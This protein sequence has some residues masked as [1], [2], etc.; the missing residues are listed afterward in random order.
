MESADFPHVNDE[1]RVEDIDVVDDA[2]NAN[3]AQIRPGE[4][5]GTN[6]AWQPVD[7]RA[8]E[9]LDEWQR[10][11]LRPHDIHDNHDTGYQPTDDS[12]YEHEEANDATRLLHEYEKHPDQ[13]RQGHDRRSNQP[14]G[15][16]KQRYGRQRDLESDAT[17][18]SSDYLALR[19]AWHTL[20]RVLLLNS[21][22]AL[23]WSLLD[24]PIV[25]L[26]R[27]AVCKRQMS[28]GSSEIG[29]A[30][31]DT[32]QASGIFDSAECRTE[33]VQSGVASVRGTLQAA[34]ALLGIVMNSFYGNMSDAVGRR[35][36]LMMSIVLLFG[37]NVWFLYM[38]QNQQLSP[39]LALVGAAMLGAAG[40]VSS[41]P[42]M[43]NSII[44][45]VAPQNHQSYFLGC[46][47]AAYYIGLCIG[48]FASGV[49]I[50]TF[51]SLLPNLVATC[52]IW[53]ICLLYVFMLIPETA[54]KAAN[55]G[56]NNRST[57]SQGRELAAAD[58]FACFKN[59]RESVQDL[60][61]N[62]F[63]PFRGR[64]PFRNCSP[65][66]LE[67]Q[68]CYDDSFSSKRVRAV[69]LLALTMALAILASGAIGLLPLFV[70][71][72]FGWG[73]R[74]A[75]YLVT[76]NPVLSAII[77][78]LLL[79]KL[80]QL[81]AKISVKRER[82]SNHQHTT[83]KK[84][85]GRRNGDII[86]NI[87][88]DNSNDRNFDEISKVRANAGT[89]S[90]DEARGDASA[91]PDDLISA[92]K[93]HNND[94]DRSRNEDSAPNE[95]QQL[96]PKSVYEDITAAQTDLQSQKPRNDRIDRS[97][98]DD[99]EDAGDEDDDLQNS[100][101][102]VKE[103]HELRC[104]LW[105]ARIGFIL[106]IISG[107]ILFF[108]RSVVMVVTAVAMEAMGNIVQP[109]IQALALKGTRSDYSGR[110]LAFMATVEGVA[111][112]LRGLFFA[113]VYNRTIAF[114]PSAMFLIASII[115]VLCLALLMII[116]M[117][118]PIK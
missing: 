73:P 30:V 36:V 98:D 76:I 97:S 3:D 53:S 40:Y 114:N 112:V 45:D 89:S 79:P 47:N 48:P 85:Y 113:F 107:I 81:V 58:K 102:S 39:W 19:R 90:S 93:S 103:I 4:S 94:Y 80:H 13:Q 18:S 63:Q 61:L 117:Y 21:L 91:S 86:P 23:S 33:S 59:F 72:K 56:L 74:Q 12:G 64:L 111:L 118:R 6:H 95:D 2:D 83:G 55:Q 49:L 66:E 10:S 46:N 26:L 32:V 108:A 7:R 68:V 106:V 104:D 28:M 51:D 75:G 87:G 60:W 57:A 22:Q 11:R 20:W 110:I 31:A 115:Y 34:A 14:K 37:G 24:L 62:F 105:I 41:L 77:L 27:V 50:D 29:A 43:L 44:A 70:D 38:S 1:E 84:D 78:S 67:L 15:D 25:Y 96:S 116:P 82:A 5:V 69:T 16:G 17:A 92:R 52:S 71:Y 100:R 99:V 101:L 9:Q 54:P 35:P 8:Q 65:R 42:A 88:D 109:S